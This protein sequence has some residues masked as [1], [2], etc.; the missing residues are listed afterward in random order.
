MNAT[1]KPPRR[2]RNDRDTEP[3]ERQ[4]AIFDFI[5]THAI[6]HLYQPSLR[7]MMEHFGIGSPNGFMC[8]LRGLNQKG[9]IDLSGKKS[10]SIRILRK[11][12]IEVEDLAE[13]ALRTDHLG[14]L[15]GK[16][17]GTLIYIVTYAVEHF[18]QPSLEDVAYRFGLSNA[19]SARVRLESLREKGWIDFGSLSCRAIRILR[20]P[21]IIVDYSHL[22]E[23]EVAS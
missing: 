20:K 14:P 2:R 13:W 1:R 7:E 6:E 10:R 18:Y 5:V 4:R 23:S 3:T 8:H 21:A 16:L 22:V 15:S 11:P 9:W 19:S 12:A 17:R